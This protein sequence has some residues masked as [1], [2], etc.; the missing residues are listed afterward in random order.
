M[1]MNAQC[2]PCR[3]LFFPLLSLS[4]SAGN[5]ETISGVQK[6]EASPENLFFSNTYFKLV[7][8]HLHIRT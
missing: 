4:D 3:S 8:V 7:K 1:E 6:V 5:K 2:S